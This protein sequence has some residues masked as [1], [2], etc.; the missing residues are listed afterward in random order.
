[1]QAYYGEKR[2]GPDPS[3]Q[4]RAELDGFYSAIL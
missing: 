3:N 4:D 2:Y 1:M